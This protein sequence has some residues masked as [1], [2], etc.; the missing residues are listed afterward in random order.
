MHPALE[1]ARRGWSVFPLRPNTKLPYMGFKWRDK[2]SKDPAQLQEWIDRYPKCNWGVDCS[3][4]GIAVVDVDVKD[5]KDGLSTLLDLRL[6]GFDLPETMVIKTPSGGEHHVYEG[7]CKNSVEKLGSGL[8]TRGVGGYILVPGSVVDGFPYEITHDAEL[9]E[10]PLWVCQS[11]GTPHERDRTER[12]DSNVE[13]D[14][15]ANLLRA[16]DFLLAAEP[17]LQG[18]GGDAHTFQIA[19]KV[20]DLGISE[21]AC[22]SLMLG[23]WNPRCEPPWEVEELARKVNNAYTYANSPAGS[24]TMEGIFSSPIVHTFPAEISGQIQISP[25]EITDMFSLADFSGT[26]PDREWII[27]GWIPANEKI[28]FAGKEGLGKSLAALQLALST[29]YGIPWLGNRVE[30]PMAALYVSCEDSKDEVHRRIA[31]IRN[32]PEYAFLDANNIDTDMFKVVSRA[33][34]DNALGIE[35]DWQLKKGPFFDQLIARCELM[36]A[37]RM[38]IILDTLAD[39]FAGN[40]N[41]RTVVNTFVKHYLG[42]IQDRFNATIVTLAHPPKHGDTVYS[43]STAWPAAHRS[44]ISIEESPNEN[45]VDHRVLKLIK[46]NYGRAGAKLDL[47]WK[48]GAY[49]AIEGG[50]IF[51]EVETANLD[52]LLGKVRYYAEK[53][54]QLSMH[55]LGMLPLKDTGIRGIDGEFLAWDV[56]KRLVTR[57]K[58]LGRIEDKKGAGRK[59]GLWPLVE[60][61]VFE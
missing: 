54:T 59:N 4:S 58:E 44:V 14:Q 16:R 40:E 53:G 57:L 7:T 1:Y 9:G 28:L 29:A 51:D 32:Q 23:D 45:L 31:G 61:S 11:A 41:S 13:L 3:K 34:E 2:S 22:L 33:G 8:D 37:D 20:N 50:E 49:V 26:P 15:S 47:Q 6:Q 60:R 56:K 25:E 5:G 52:I 55:S 21:N 12:A 19:C 17:A 10:I 30:T 38:L 24:G 39:V 27:E 42:Q 46:I 48:R 35:K 18:Q 36:K 43:G